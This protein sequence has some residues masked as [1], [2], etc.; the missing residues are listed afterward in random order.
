LLRQRS[1]KIARAKCLKMQEQFRQRL[2]P[3]LGKINSI[4]AMIHQ[5]MEHQPFQMM[6]AW[7][8]VLNV[9]MVI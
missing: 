8:K 4:M 2:L 3:V 9:L 6:A 1:L 5:H 7:M